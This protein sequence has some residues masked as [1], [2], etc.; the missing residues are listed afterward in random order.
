MRW[1]RSILCPVAGNLE[2]DGLGGGPAWL[3]NEL[4]EAKGTWSIHVDGVEK[5]RVL[6]IAKRTFDLSNE[7]GLALMRSFPVLPIGTRAEAERMAGLLSAEGIPTTVW[8]VR[9]NLKE[10]SEQER[11]DVDTAHALLL[12]YGIS[13]ASVEEVSHFSDGSMSVITRENDQMWHLGIEFDP[14][15]TASLAA[16]FLTI[17]VPVERHRDRNS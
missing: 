7:E 5:M 3:R 12:D 6:Q 1:Y 16:A 14:D 13:P 11:P 9:R 2:E 17:G 8:T 15:L 10:I 4:L